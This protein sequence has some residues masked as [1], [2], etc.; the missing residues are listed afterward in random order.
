MKRIAG[1]AAAMVVGAQAWVW[2]AP[3]IGD[4]AG[5]ALPWANGNGPAIPDFGPLP[6]FPDPPC[7]TCVLEFPKMPAAAIT[8][9]ELSAMALASGPFAQCQGAAAGSLGDLRSRA[10]GELGDQAW[11]NSQLSSGC[12]R[13]ISRTDLQVRLLSKDPVCLP[14][15]QAQSRAMDAAD[16]INT[17]TVQVYSTLQ[18]CTSTVASQI[19]SSCDSLRQMYDILSG[20]IGPA[21]MSELIKAGAAVLGKLPGS[22]N[23]FAAQL[24]ETKQQMQALNCPNTP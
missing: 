8:D 5:Q 11:V 16:A 10:Q 21:A 7:F 15:W 12:H 4:P 3:A 20:D 23:P 9:D 19:K 6:D 13:P 24:V 2:G 22:E 17:Q 18:T 14:V 1:V